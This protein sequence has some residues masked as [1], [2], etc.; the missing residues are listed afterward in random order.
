MESVGDQISRLAFLTLYSDP[1]I[2]T[3]LQ[4]ILNL[5]DSSFS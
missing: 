3:P 4:K 2:E 5:M 1:N